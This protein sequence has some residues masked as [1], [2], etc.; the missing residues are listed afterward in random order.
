LGSGI[1][2]TENPPVTWVSGTMVR[3]GPELTVS[4]FGENTFLAGLNITEVGVYYR[5]DSTDTTGRPIYSEDGLTD[6]W[7][8]GATLNFATVITFTR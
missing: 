4:G 8:A 3:D 7:I 5:F 6:F 2:V 1:S